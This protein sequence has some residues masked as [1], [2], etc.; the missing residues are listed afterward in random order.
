MPSPFPG[1]DPFVELQESSDFHA[2]YMTVI[3]E[4]LAP[5]YGDSTGSVRV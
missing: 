4:L 1:M 5:H 3:R 2:T